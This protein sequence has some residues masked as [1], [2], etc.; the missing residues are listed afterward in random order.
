M[1]YALIGSYTESGNGSGAGVS[2]VLL[3]PDGLLASVDAVGAGLR[4]PSFLAVDPLNADVLYAV[5]ELDD[6]ALAELDASTLALRRRT[7]TSGA[8]PCHVAVVGSGADAGAGRT[9][10]AANYSSGS[11]AVLPADGAWAGNALDGSATSAGAPVLL[12]NPGIGPVA[13]RQEQSHAHQSV[14]TPWGTVLVADLGAD[15]VDEYSAAAPHMLLGSATLPPGA[16]PRHL[17]LLGDVLLV[18][19]ELDA[20]LHIFSRDG[21]AAGESGADKAP[22]QSRPAPC[23]WHWQYS[24]ALFDDTHPAFD[25]A[26]DRYPSHLQ[27]SADGAVVYA[28]IRGRD[29]IAV[30]DVSAL[31]NGTGNG[32]GDRNGNGSASAARPVLLDEVPCGGAWPRHFAVEGSKL[33]VANERSHTIAV[34]AL[35]EAGV[36]GAEPLQQFPLNSPTCILLP[37]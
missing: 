34:F 14:P 16:G 19:G 5:E 33:Y 17:V 18:A 3:G 11:V 21:G 2:R 25:A 23:V 32:T 24:V 12:A 6:G 10:W 31:G 15:R 22:G 1:T 4:N 36:P 9:V 37:N 26:A 30:V 7:P 29:S 8:H 27:A 28:A 35:D 13:D 20:R